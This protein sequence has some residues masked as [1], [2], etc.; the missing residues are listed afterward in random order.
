MKKKAVFRVSLADE[1]KRAK[2]LKAASGFAGVTKVES[3]SDDRS[4]LVVEGEDL[5]VM[6]LSHRLEKKLGRGVAVLL[7]LQ[8]ADKDKDKDGIKKIEELFYNG[9]LP[10]HPQPGYWAPPYGTPAHPYYSPQVYADPYYED[11][12]RCSIM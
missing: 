9:Y 7:T 6:G 3:P 10:V 8:P 2:A 5:E 12:P 4:K 1:K 11:S